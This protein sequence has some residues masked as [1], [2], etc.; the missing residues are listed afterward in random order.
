MASAAESPE[1]ISETQFQRSLQRIA[2]HLSRDRKAAALYDLPALDN[3]VS[4]SD[5]EMKRDW[6]QQFRPL[7][8]LVLE[9]TKAGCRLAP[10]VAVD[11]SQ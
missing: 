1:K 5:E 10:P 9:R 4:S 7:C 6:Q 8:L 11:R 3:K 2:L